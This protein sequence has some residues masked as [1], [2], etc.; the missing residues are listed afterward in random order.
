MKVRF[1]GVRGA[2]AMAGAEYLRYG[3]NTTAVEVVAASGRR[4]CAWCLPTS[5]MNTP[6]WCTSRCS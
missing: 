3:G 6:S 5:P 2:F 1:W 4:C